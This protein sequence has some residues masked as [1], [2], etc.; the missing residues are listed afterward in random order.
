MEAEMAQDAE[1]KEL[2]YFDFDALEVPYDLGVM[3]F[4]PPPEMWERYRKLMGDPEVFIT[5]AMRPRAIATYRLLPP[6]PGEQHINAGHDAQ[7]FNPPRPGK[8]LLI[9]SAIVEKYVRRG[10]PYMITQ[11]E[12]KDEDGVLIE[13]FRRTSMVKSPKLGQK[14]WAKPT[15]ETEVGAELDPVV[16][17][18][19]LEMMKDFEAL[20]GLAR[21]EG[22][23]NFH[24]DEALA[25][26]AGLREP[27]ASAHMTISYM[28]E[29]LNKFF[30]HDWVQGGTLSLKFIRP[31]I[32]GDKVAYK[33]RVMDKVPE[34]NR[35]RLKLEV[36]TENQRGQQTAVGTASGLVD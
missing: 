35:V 5:T 32:A 12:V 23:E 1:K 18:F 11:T 9:H 29:L 22:P 19:T 8:K 20:Y 17:T 25:Q 21:G 13:Q 28:H 4:T 36:W 27:I 15:R 10:K 24:S 2:K 26:T 31:I 30:G 33:G 14:W 6:R 16:K 34:G 7:Y 3:E